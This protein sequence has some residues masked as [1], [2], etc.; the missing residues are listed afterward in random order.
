MFAVTQSAIFTD[1]TKDTQIQTAVQFGQILRVH[2]NSELL[3]YYSTKKTFIKIYV[4][5]PSCNS[6]KSP[7]FFSNSATHLNLIY[8]QYD[9]YIQC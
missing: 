9:S 5:S 1:K 7:N 8:L 2:K 3:K 6:F 4:L